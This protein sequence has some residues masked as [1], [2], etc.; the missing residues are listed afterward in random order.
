MDTWSRRKFLKTA[1]ATCSSLIMPCALPSFAKQTPLK[2][3][4]LPITDA[5]PLLV[6]H[7]LGY[8]SQEGLQV[9]KPVMVR[10]WKILIESFLAG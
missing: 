6:A 5:T 10:S 8:F 4:Y 1:A 9:E 3:G 2:L 7:G